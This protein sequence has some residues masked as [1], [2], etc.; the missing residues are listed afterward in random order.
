L[1]GCLPSNV[2]DVIVDVIVEAALWA[3]WKQRVR[4]NK[5]GDMSD[6]VAGQASATQTAAMQAAAIDAVVFDLDGVILDSEQVW[7]AIRHEFVVCHG[8]HWTEDDQKAVMGANSRQWVVHIRDS[9]GVDLSPEEIFTSVVAALRA[10]YEAHLPLLPGA[11]EAVHALAADF[12]L[13]VASSSPLELVEAALV[14]AGLRN[15]FQAV[16]SSDEVSHG[17]PEPD[18]YREVCRRLGCL[19]GRAVAIEDSSNGIQAALAAGLFVIAV[20]NPIYSP[21]PSVVRSAH[22]VLG[23]ILR[24]GYPIQRWRCEQLD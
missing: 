10:S 11:V 20:P 4:D 3:L 23:R 1:H 2:D 8:G 22:I 21:P 12:R 9:C 19:P 13:G 16:V 14:L 18:V 6:A 5:R 24:G 7:N 15:R 17:K